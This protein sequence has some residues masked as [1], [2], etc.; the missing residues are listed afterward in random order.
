[1]G[2]VLNL[3][4]PMRY[5]VRE[6]FLEMEK[7]V[8]LMNSVLLDALST[9]MKSEL[10][11]WPTQ[12][13]QTLVDLNSSS[14]LLTTSSWTFLISHLHLNTQS[15]ERLSVEWM[16]LMPSIQPQQGSTIQSLLSKSEVFKL[17]V[18]LV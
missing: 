8:S 1:M 9:Q 14:I 11:L 4:L 17:Q 13:N 2:V 16:L 3:V 12:V 6:P 15:L 7:V 10:F 5:Q 18:K